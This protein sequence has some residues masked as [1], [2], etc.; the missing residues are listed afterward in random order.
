MFCTSRGASVSDEH[1]FCSGYGRP[2]QKP[3]AT[4]RRDR[5]EIIEAHP[6]SPQRSYDA[7]PTTQYRPT[8]PPQH[9]AAAPVYVTQ[10]VQVASPVAARPPKGV[11]CI[12][13]FTTTGAVT[14]AWQRALRR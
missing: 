6:V 14:P 1:T 2:I 3:P 7:P 12:V 4:A 9:S 10:Q 13:P 5:V 8:P 11:G